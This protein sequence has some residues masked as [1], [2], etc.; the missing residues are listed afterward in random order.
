M[1][2]EAAGKMAVAL[3]FRKPAHGIHFEPG[4]KN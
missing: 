1:W 4:V 3:A 2:I